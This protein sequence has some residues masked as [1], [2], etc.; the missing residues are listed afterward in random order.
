MIAHET[1][2]TNYSKLTVAYGYEIIDEIVNPT[3]KEINFYNKKY[4]FACV[5]VVGYNEIKFFV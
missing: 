4:P 5:T 3:K 2:T 1:Q